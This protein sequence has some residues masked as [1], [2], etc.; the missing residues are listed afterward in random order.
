[1]CGCGRVAV[2]DGVDM[3]LVSRGPFGLAQDA[4]LR[5][6]LQDRGCRGGSRSRSR[7]R[8]IAE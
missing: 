6:A 8:T 1:M 2:K 4:Q 3:G 5:C 7:S